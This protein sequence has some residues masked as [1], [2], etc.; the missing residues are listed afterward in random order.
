MKNI[1]ILFAVIMAFC[2][3]TVTIVLAWWSGGED[4]DYYTFWQGNI[5]CT[6]SDCNK[7]RNCGTLWYQ[8]DCFS[9]WFDHGCIRDT[10]S[11]QSGPVLGDEQTT[12]QC[13]IRKG[14]CRCWES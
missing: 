7:G 2:F 4:C 5:Q 10:C 11:L 12:R 8:Y 13:G 9:S 14:R 1:I 3:G 6:T